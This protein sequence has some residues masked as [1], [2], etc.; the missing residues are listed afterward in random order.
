MRRLLVTSML[1]VAAALTTGCHAGGT[2]GAATKTIDITMQSGHA[3]SATGDVV[4][5]SA[6]QQVQLLIKA[7]RG[8][9]LTLHASPAR[10]IHYGMG[11]TLVPIGSFDQPGMIAI[12]SDSATSSV[13]RI[14]VDGA[15]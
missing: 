11:T 15:A 1:V 12:T 10:T 7:D 6:G 3:A 8:G 14:A 4:H 2:T 5:V 9:T 13:V